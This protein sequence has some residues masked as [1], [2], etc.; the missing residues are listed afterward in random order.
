[1]YSYPN[2]DTPLFKD[3][4]TVLE[5][6]LIWVLEQRQVC[7]A[8]YNLKC[9]S[10]ISFGDSFY[11]LTL[12]E[13]FLVWELQKF[14]VDNLS[15]SKNKPPLNSIGRDST[16]VIDLDKNRKKTITEHLRIN[17][18]FWNNLLDSSSLIMNTSSNWSLL[19]YYTYSWIIVTL[20]FLIFQNKFNLK[21]RIIPKWLE[22]SVL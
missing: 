13:N 10:S 4:E 20:I 11:I 8:S 2:I 18:I 14:D 15:T 22:L 16:N 21:C 17:M 9:F 7:M 5:Q 3:K 12:F 19:L 1:M 6:S